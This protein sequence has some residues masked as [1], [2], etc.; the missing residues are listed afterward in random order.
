MP[1]CLKKKKKTGKLTLGG[2]RTFILKNKKHLY[3]SLGK[4]YVV[5]FK[6][7]I[8]ADAG[9]YPSGHILYIQD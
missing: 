8:L 5:Y 4:K 2:I 1:L 9:A 7:P 6:M 3:A